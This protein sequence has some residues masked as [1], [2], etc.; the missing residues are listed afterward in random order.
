MS[1]TVGI[2]KGVIAYND[3]FAHQY[4]SQSLEHMAHSPPPT[5][6]NQE[7]VVARGVVLGL[8]ALNRKGVISSPPNTDLPK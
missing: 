8:V 5:T 3:I 6:Q 1:N 4:P 2:S 7:A